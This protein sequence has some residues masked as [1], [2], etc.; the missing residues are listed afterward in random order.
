M[1]VI[2]YEYKKIEKAVM[3]INSLV[4]SGIQNVRALSELSD[5]LD[6][7]NPGEIEKSD[8]NSVEKKEGE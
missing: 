5:I 3:L 8:G 2:V 4:V 6:S 7:G 1:K